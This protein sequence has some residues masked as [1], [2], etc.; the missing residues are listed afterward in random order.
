[1]SVFHTSIE[2]I[3]AIIFD[4]IPSILHPITTD[5]PQAR[6]HS[7]GI[8]KLLVGHGLG[9]QGHQQPHQGNH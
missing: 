6:Q 4:L 1:M 2:A 7:L 8:D 3:K 9:S 5:P